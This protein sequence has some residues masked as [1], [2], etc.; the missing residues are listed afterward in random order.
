MLSNVNFA[1]VEK[2]LV[3]FAVNYGLN[4]IGAVLICIFGF[5]AAHLFKRLLKR[6]LSSKR[7]DQTVSNFFADV[8]YYIIVAI[9]LIAALSQLG[10]QTTSF[11][12]LIGAITIGIGMSLKGTLSQF[13]S[14][15]I[16]VSSRPFKIGQTV[17]IDGTMGTV[18]KISILFTTL[19]SFDN[20]QIILPNNKVIAAKIVNYSQNDTRRINLIIGISYDDDIDKAKGILTQIA[21]QDA[22]ILD[23]PAP[24]IVVN[25]LGDSSVNLLFRVWVKNADFADVKFDCTESIK[26][27]LDQN[28][29]NIP[30]P[31]RDVH[32]IQAV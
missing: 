11:V 17:E 22:R 14:G 6:V 25:D 3:D 5:I 7:L 19:K 20:Q 27:A 13:T 2:L 18:K 1:M 12:A 4:I 15:L 8:L 31:Q 32:L 16:V 23:D 21:E 30:F 9:V 24:K 26:K 10:V 29:I 28:G